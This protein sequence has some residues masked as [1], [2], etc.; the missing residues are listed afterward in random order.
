ML[1][2]TSLAVVVGS[3]REVVELG[4]VVLFMIMVVRKLLIPQYHRCKAWKDHLWLVIYIGDPEEDT[5]IYWERLKSTGVTREVFSG[6]MEILQSLVRRSN[7]EDDK[8]SMTFTS[9]EIQSATRAMLDSGKYHYRS[10]PHKLFC[11]LLS[12]AVRFKGQRAQR[13]ALDPLDG[14]LV[15]WPS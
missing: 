6:Q 3:T 8:N 15:D 12:H 1:F 5:K 14:M 10:D 2:A 9:D 11:A 7:I 13:E 4:L